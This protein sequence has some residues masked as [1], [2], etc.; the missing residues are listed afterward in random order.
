MHVYRIR[1][2]LGESFRLGI[3]LRF[4]PWAGVKV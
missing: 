1:L 3:E 4:R 2:G